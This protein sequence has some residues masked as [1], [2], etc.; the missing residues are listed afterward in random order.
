L[1]EIKQLYLSHD[2][3]ALALYGDGIKTAR[4]VETEPSIMSRLSLV[5]Y[6]LND[7]TTD[8]TKSQI[9]N[10]AIAEEAFNEMR[11]QLN[12]LIIRTKKIEVQ[13][14]NLHI[15]Y[16]QG[17]EYANLASSVSGGLPFNNYAPLSYTQAQ[18]TGCAQVDQNASFVHDATPIVE[19]P[20]FSSFLQGGKSM[21]MIPLF[22][23]SSPLEITLQ[24]DTAVNSLVGST[25]GMTNFTLSE[26]E[27]RY[28]SVNP[29]RQYIDA[30]IQG[31]SGGKTFAIDYTTINSFKTALTASLSVNQSVNSKSVRAVAISTIP[32]TEQ[33][34]NARKRCQAPP[35]ALPNSTLTTKRIFFDNLPL[36]NYPDSLAQ[37][38]DNI[39]ETVEAVYGNVYDKACGNL[40]FSQIGSVGQSGNYL[41]T[42]HSTVIGSDNY[43]D[44]DIIMTGTP[45]NVI[46][47]DLTYQGAASGDIANFY[48]FVEKVAFFGL[49]T[50]AI[51]Q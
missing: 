48:C 9:A 42:F 33:A 17:K 21:E 35:N 30:L 24:L 22:C 39:M 31:M 47:Y 19:I 37:A 15:P 41:S 1:N 2:R 51:Q 4:E 26:V 8:A 10:K 40:P 36:V 23:M 44:A 50:L 13:L 5:E 18:S 6:M 45:C 20:L 49:G 3:C 38:S 46:R 11:A 34:I 27:L 32:A 28:S 16:I 25:T 43:N 29:S 14:D 12:E 7:N